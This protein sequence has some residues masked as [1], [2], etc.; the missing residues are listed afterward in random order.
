MMKRLLFLIP[1]ILLIIGCN[2]IFLSNGNGKPVSFLGVSNNWKGE[3]SAII[4]ENGPR[5]DGNSSV[6][7]EK[8]KN[9]SVFRI[10]KSNINNSIFNS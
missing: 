4:S 9:H 6:N 8:I 7:V 2:E 5:E 10:A 3:Y 1:F